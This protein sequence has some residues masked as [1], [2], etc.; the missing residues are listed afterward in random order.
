MLTPTHEKIVWLDVAMDETPGVDKLNPRELQVHMIHCFNQRVEQQ[1]SL[2]SGLIDTFLVEARRGGST[3]YCELAG[4]CRT[5]NS[6]HGDPQR[7]PERNGG[8]GKSEL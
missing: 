1:Q 2:F 3:F 5:L 8:Q 4:S 6:T 7:S